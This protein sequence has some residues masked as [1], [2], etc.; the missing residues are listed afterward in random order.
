MEFILLYF[1]GFWTNGP[2]S[3]SNVNNIKMWKFNCKTVDNQS[4]KIFLT[5][6]YKSIIL[7]INK[8]TFILFYLS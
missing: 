5:Y 2:V 4:N 6:S 3:W 1:T 7:I 8:I